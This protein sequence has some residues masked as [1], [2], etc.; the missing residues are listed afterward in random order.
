MKQLMGLAAICWLVCVPT[1]A[2]AGDRWGDLRGR[3]IVE[4]TPPKLKP[5]AVLPGVP[6]VPDESLLVDEKTGGLQ[7]VLIFL[8]RA[9]QT[10]HPELAQPRENEIEFKISAFRFQPHVLLVRTGQKVRI[11]MKDAGNSGPYGTP[12]KNNKFNLLVGLNR[13][14][15]VVEFTKSET[16]PFEVRDDIHP[17]MKASWMVLD[18]PYAAITTADGSFAIDNLPSGSHEFRV[19]HERAGWLEKSGAVDITTGEVTEW[20]LR[21]PLERFSP[22]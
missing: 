2:L 15:P 19:W 8:R 16:I 13:E 1:E 10:I 11:C 17:W 9:P 18:H 12:I 6:P 7:N 14:Q 3:V 21:Y 4:G 22:Q 20:T 5:L